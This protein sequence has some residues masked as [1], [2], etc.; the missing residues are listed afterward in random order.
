VHVAYDE[1]TAVLAG[2]A[3]LTEAF[4]VLSEPGAGAAEAALRTVGS[5]A[6]A[7]GGAGLVGGQSDDLRFS[8]GVGT[9]GSGEAGSREGSD[10]ARLASIHARKTAALFQAAIV[11]GAVLAGATETERERLDAFG[12]DIGVAFQIADDLLDADSEEAASILRIQGLEDARQGAEGLLARALLQIE[13]LCERAEPLRELARF[14]VR[15]NR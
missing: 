15:R 10:Y 9:A 12:K 7:A 4:A 1:A 5:L 8:S 6:K 2:D 14:A 11:G 13:D 3:L